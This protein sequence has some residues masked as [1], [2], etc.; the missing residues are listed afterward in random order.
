[1]LRLARL[2]LGKYGIMLHQ[3]NFISGIRITLISKALHPFPNWH[4]SL[5]SQLTDNNRIV[6][7]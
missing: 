3:P 4:I 1:M 5:M 7:H 2:P 6:A